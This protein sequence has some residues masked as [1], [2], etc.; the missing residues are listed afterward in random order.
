MTVFSG[1]FAERGQSPK[2]KALV[3]Q[4]LAFEKVTSILEAKDIAVEIIVPLSTNHKMK[5]KRKKLENQERYSVFSRNKY[6]NAWE[7]LDVLS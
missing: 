6:Q 2:Q 4:E 7:L 5:S 3:E 1:S